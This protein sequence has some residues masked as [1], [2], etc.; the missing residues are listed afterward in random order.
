MERKALVTGG[1]RGIGRAIAE[2]LLRQGVGVAIASRHPGEAAEA[3]KREGLP[4]LAL[5]VDLEKDPP[6]ALV[7]EA[8]EALG[9]LHILVHAAA[10]NVSTS[11]ARGMWR[12]SSPCPFGKT[13]PSMGPSPPASP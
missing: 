6:E 8:A 9:G 11:S 3:L 7:A 10:V 12:R 5:P 13:P 2:A 1:S 4:A